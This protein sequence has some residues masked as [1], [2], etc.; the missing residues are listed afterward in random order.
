MKKL[1]FPDD[2]KVSKALLKQEMISN[3]RELLISV[4]NKKWGGQQQEIINKVQN[5]YC[6]MCAVSVNMK[7]GYCVHS[8]SFILFSFAFADCYVIS[9]MHVDNFP[10]KN[11]SVRFMLVLQLCK[12]IEDKKYH[13]HISSQ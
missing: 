1:L 5:V 9:S 10:M 2:W 13:I 12:K 6:L 7:N 8:F 11:F 4:Y 3:F